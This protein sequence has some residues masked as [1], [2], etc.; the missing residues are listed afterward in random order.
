V[1]KLSI[2]NLE[3]TSIILTLERHLLVGIEQIKREEERK[4]MRGQERPMNAMARSPLLH[5]LGVYL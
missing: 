3:T 4:H 1:E 5:P 2:Q